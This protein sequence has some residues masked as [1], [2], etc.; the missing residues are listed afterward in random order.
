M[1]KKNISEPSFLE[2]LSLLAQGYGDRK[3][4]TK[5]AHRIA[6][7]WKGTL[8]NLEVRGAGPSANLDIITQ[9]RIIKLSLDLAAKLRV[10]VIKKYA[11]EKNYKRRSRGQEEPGTSNTESKG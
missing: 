11:N 1:S 5:Y 4:I 10:L 9:N 6:R 7:L 2:I 3:V 8:V